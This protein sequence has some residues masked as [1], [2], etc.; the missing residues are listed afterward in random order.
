MDYNSFKEYTLEIASNKKYQWIATI[1]ILLIVLM[2]SSSIRLSNWNLLTDHTTG[3]KIPLALDPFYFLRMAETIASNNGT[4][5]KFDIMRAHGFNVGWSSELLP[6][7]IVLLWKIANTFGH[8]TIQTID[9]FSPVLFFGM[10]LILFFIL[11]YF[12]TRS[13]SAGILASTFLAFTPAYL[14][15]TMAGFSDHEAI[16]MVGFFLSMIGFVLVLKYLDKSKK[17]N[18]IGAGITGLIMGALSVFTSMAWGGVAVFL[19]MI[20]PICFALL[21]VIKMKDPENNIKDNGLLFYFTWLVSSIGF[22]FFA[23]LSL[24][25]FIGR[26]ITGSNGIISV[27]VLGFIIID[28]LILSFGK[29]IKAYNERYRILYSL[30]TSAVAGVIALPFLGKNFFSLLWIILNKFL[31]PDWGAGR[32]N[33]TIAENAQPYLINWINTVG[34]QIFWIFVA[35]AIF[36]GFEFS[37]NIKSEKNRYLFIFGY[38]AMIFGILFSRISPSSILNGNGVFSL[39]GLVCI[40]G[41]SLFI[42]AFFKNYFNSKIKVESPVLMLFAWLIVMLIVGKS[43]TRLFFVIAPFMCLV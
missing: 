28:R 1:I 26:Y 12:L 8:Y 5:P 43:T 34:V 4:L 15:R 42:Y 23:G 40:G 32:I 37:K 39:S 11:T 10:G 7:V 36:I 18:I 21:W 25:S 2:L 3:E 27:A 6:R 38:I 9:V 30:G 24:S 20:I 19:F 16:G 29:S 31:N 33:S 13:K 41:I 17:R 35:G 14:Y 22:A